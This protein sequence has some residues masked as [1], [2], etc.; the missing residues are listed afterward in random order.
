MHT[1]QFDITGRF[2]IP[3]SPQGHPVIFQA[4]DSAAGRDFAA[5]NADA[6]FT[7]HG[8]QRPGG[9]LSGR[10]STSRIAGRSPDELKVL[11]G[12]SAVIGDTHT[13]AEELADHI[14]ASTDQ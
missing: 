6:V 3:Q 14:S 7:R 2:N 11:P 12:V 1:S 9:L 8:T 4:G 5:A 10:Q 13:E